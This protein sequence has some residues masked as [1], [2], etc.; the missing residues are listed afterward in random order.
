M[1]YVGTV[2][3]SC[4]ITALAYFATALAMVPAP[5]EAEYWVRE[6]IVV[7]RSIARTYAGRRKLIVASGSATL[8]GVDAALLGRELGRPVLNFGLHGAMSL[9]RILEEAAGAATAGD[10]VVLALEPELYCARGPTAWQARSAVA[11]DREQWRTWSLSERVEAIGVLGPSRVL[12]MAAARLERAFSPGTLRR[13]LEA[14][15]DAKVLTKWRARAAPKRFAYSAYHL[16]EFGDM[17]GTDGAKFDGI[18]RPSDAE[19]TLCPGSLRLLR[20]FASRMREKDVAVR[21]ANAPYVADDRMPK[22]AVESASREFTKAISEIAPVLDSRSDTLF[23]RELFFNTEL[24]LNARGREI[25]TL[26]L[27]HAIRADAA[28]GSHLNGRLRTSRPRRRDRIILSNYL[29]RPSLS[30]RVYTCVDRRQRLGRAVRHGRG[31]C[32]APDALES[33]PQSTL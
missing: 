22:E 12:E 20:R 31:R 24:H 18:A 26:R 6:M 13:R 3:F 30:R 23:A 11:W 28:L 32:A 33:D 19:T 5:I 1:R 14:I 25:R 29:L 15:D 10:A 9:E 27:A 7:K 21:F 4:A 2:L 16:D 17:L 8:F